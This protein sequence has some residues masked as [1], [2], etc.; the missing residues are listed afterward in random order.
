MAGGVVS[1]TP[2]RP[3]DVTTTAAGD[4]TPETACT[5]PIALAFGLRAGD[6]AFS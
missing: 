4:P 1:A 6:D 3:P 2:F 5:G